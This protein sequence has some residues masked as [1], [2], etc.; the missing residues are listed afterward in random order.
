MLWKVSR[1]VVLLLCCTPIS[2][3]V[4]GERL[5]VS[6]A[7]SL[8]GALREADKSF[9]RGS[10]VE[11]TY[12]FGGSGTL[13]KQ[14]EN[15]APVDVFISAATAPV[16]AVEK[17]NLLHPGSRTNLLTN[18]LVLITS[19]ERQ[20]IQSFS[21]LT[22][23]QVKY[24][25]IGEPNSVPAGVY[26]MECFTAQNL[27]PQITPKLVRLLNVRQALAA[28][29]TG[30]ADAG[31]VYRTDAEQSKLVR[32]VAVAPLQSH[33]PILYPAAIMRRSK[34]LE[35]ARRYIAFLQSDTAR[36]IFEKHGFRFPR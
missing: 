6:A 30:N 32:I 28:V 13:Q 21:D 14:I 17:Q 3:A 5:L 29:A 25:A 36:V 19:R 10:K 31:M 26:A 4:A 8:E 35:T 33:Q 24:V 18:S 9:Q 1:A 20:D 23:R 16:D 15:G 11:I 34:N 27:T 22:G 7:A 12:N 2:L